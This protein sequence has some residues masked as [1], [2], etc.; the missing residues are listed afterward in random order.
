VPKKRAH[1][2]FL[3]FEEIRDDDANALTR[4]GGCGEDDELL[5]GQAN[6]ILAEF[7]YNYSVGAIF[8]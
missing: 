6:Q 4:T 2:R 7:A 1:V 3:V 8:E 5:S